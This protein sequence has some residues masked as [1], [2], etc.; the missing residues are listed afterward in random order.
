VHARGPCG[1]SSHFYV[2]LTGAAR[3]GWRHFGMYVVAQIFGALVASAL[4]FFVSSGVEGGYN[5]AAGGLGANGYG[6]HSPGL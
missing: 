4:I 5:F 2:Q 1:R 3:C 6:A